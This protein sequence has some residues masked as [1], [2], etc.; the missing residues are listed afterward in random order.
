MALRGRI[1][2]QNP[3][4]STLLHPMAGILDLISSHPGRSLQTQVA[5]GTHGL[6][7]QGNRAHGRGVHNNDT[8]VGVL[9]N[10]VR[11]SYSGADNDQRIPDRTTD[12][13]VFGGGKG[14]RPN[15]QY[16]TFVNGTENITEVGVDSTGQLSVGERSWSEY[17]FS[18]VEGARVDMGVVSHGGTVA[19]SLAGSDS[20][21]ASRVA[22][23]T[24]TTRACG[25]PSVQ[26]S[27]NTTAL[28]ALLS[29]RYCPT[30]ILSTKEVFIGGLHLADAAYLDNRLFHF[31]FII[32]VLFY[33][34]K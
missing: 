2:S 21:D 5:Q 31:Y 32:S 1:Q 28:N 8:S 16:Q 3:G 7:Q 27:R 6:G 15:N 22:P 10:D 11:R 9:N 4:T 34:Y 12:A 30:S 19:R 23:N 20:A 14:T 24:T 26:Q 13:L 33:Q 18:G 17:D 25:A 29:D